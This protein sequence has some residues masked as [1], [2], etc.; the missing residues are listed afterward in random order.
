M[1]VKQG[2]IHFRYPGD[3][4][5]T[6]LLGVV[7]RFLIT[8]DPTNSPSSNPLLDSSTWRYYGEIPQ[9]PSPLDTLHFSMLDHL[10][11]LLVESPELKIRGLHGGLSIWFLKNTSMIMDEANGARD[12]WQR[13]NASSLHDQIVQ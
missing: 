11:H 2:N 8:E 6:N 5:H 12:D 4:Q 3:G 9:A 1:R 7:S 10:R 13:K